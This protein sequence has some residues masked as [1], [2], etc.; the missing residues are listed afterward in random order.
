[1]LRDSKLLPLDVTEKDWIIQ[2][3]LSYEQNQELKHVGRW[4]FAIPKNK[5]NET[6]KYAR[7]LYKNDELVNCKY[8]MCSTG[9]DA[10]SKN[11]TIMFFFM[12]V[13]RMKH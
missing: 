8:L 11:G 9:A 13:P 5:L 2:T 12:R 7:R 3:Q 10:K 4:A 6:W 1:M